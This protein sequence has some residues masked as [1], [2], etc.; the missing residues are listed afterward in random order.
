M[1]DLTGNLPPMPWRVPG[2]ISFPWSETRRW[3]AELT[4]ARWGTP[5][6][7]INWPARRSQTSE[8][9]RV[10]TGALR[11][12]QRKLIVRDMFHNIR[13]T[14]SWP[15][16][17]GQHG[18]ASRGKMMR[19]THNRAASRFRNT[20]NKLFDTF[21]L[22]ARS[23]FRLVS[24]QINDSFHSAAIAKLLLLRSDSRRARSAAAFSID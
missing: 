22:E 1:R 14:N 17:V 23:A 7:V 6:A 3:R 4:L 5:E 19:I 20:L 9:Q 11:L 8:T 12:I 24:E 13:W 21:G 10:R 16:S 2:P 18:T 15:R